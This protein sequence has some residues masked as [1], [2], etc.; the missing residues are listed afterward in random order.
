[1]PEFGIG[2]E[3]LSRTNDNHSHFWSVERV[4][5]ASIRSFDPNES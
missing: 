2:S 4:V 5:S 1:M 3:G